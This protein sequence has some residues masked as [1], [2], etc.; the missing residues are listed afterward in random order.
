MIKSLW[1]T[2]P[3]VLSGKIDDEIVLM[4]VEAGYYFTLDP[5]ASRIWELLSQHPLSI[6]EL[7]D[8]LIEEYN[9]EKEQ[10]IS[11]IECFVNDMSSKN[12]IEVVKD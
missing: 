7:A 11:D 4:S 8:Q 2:V 3:S 6:D 5:V 12:L 1:K 10:C 9:I